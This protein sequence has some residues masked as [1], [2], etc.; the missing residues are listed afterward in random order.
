MKRHVIAV[1]AVV[2]A[3]LMLFAVPAA[4][5]DGPGRHAESNDWNIPLT[6]IGIL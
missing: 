2:V 1:L 6:N 5:Q 3:A 4:A